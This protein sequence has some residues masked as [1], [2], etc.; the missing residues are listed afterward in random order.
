MGRAPFAA[1]SN[2]LS[3]PRL[4]SIMIQP[5]CFGA[6]TPRHIAS[7]IQAPRLVGFYCLQCVYS[8]LPH[9]G[10]TQEWGAWWARKRCM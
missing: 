3:D 5:P 9:L 7:T 6:I 1:D 4:A 10:L 2:F 8:K